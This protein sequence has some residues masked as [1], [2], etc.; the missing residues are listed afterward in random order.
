MHVNL[1]AENGHHGDGLNQGLFNDR[2]GWQELIPAYT[3]LPTGKYSCIHIYTR[4]L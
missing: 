3:L 4:E 2:S 1:Q